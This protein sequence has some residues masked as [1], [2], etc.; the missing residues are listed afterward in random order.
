LRS[1]SATNNSII[2]DYAY[3]PTHSAPSAKP[4]SLLIYP[5]G[6]KPNFDIHATIVAYQ[7]SRNYLQKN[8][9]LIPRKDYISPSDLKNYY[10]ILRSEL[11]EDLTKNQNDLEVFDRKIAQ[12]QN[13]PVLEFLFARKEQISDNIAFEKSSIDHFEVY[14]D[15]YAKLEKYGYLD[16]KGNV[17]KSISYESLSQ[18][19]YDP[20]TQEMYS[21]II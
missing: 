21:V 14:L 10:E 12:Y 18:D 6:K 2:N 20:L 1:I 4:L 15:S 9:L 17:V 13:N 11:Y 8:D 7:N 19:T 5:A 3:S 16:S